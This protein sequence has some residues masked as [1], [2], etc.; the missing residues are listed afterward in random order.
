MSRQAPSVEETIC[1]TAQDALA[2]IMDARDANA[3]VPGIEQIIALN[4]QYPDASAL[5]YQISQL[6]DAYRGAVEMADDPELGNAAA[7]TVV[8][9]LQNL[10]NF[11]GTNGQ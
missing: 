4:L 8:A 7:M 9:S 11:C 2:R 6:A 1:S 10:V 3:G 5:F